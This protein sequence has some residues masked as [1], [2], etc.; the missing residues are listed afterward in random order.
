MKK[1][2]KFLF[3][4]FY[5]LPAVL[6]HGCATTQPQ[7]GVPIFA[8]ARM[9]ANYYETITPFPERMALYIDEDLA[10]YRHERV[11]APTYEVGHSLAPM[12]IEAFQHSFNE[13]VFLEVEPNASIASRYDITYTVWVKLKEFESF[14]RS[15]ETQTCLVL[16]MEVYDADFKKLATFESEGSHSH[17]RG[18]GAKKLGENMGESFENAIT[19]LIESFQKMAKQKQVVL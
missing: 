3:V 7:A 18:I 10:L 13:F 16:T 2:L 19:P 15:K 17:T 14:L 1:N 11:N 6:F 8:P 12:L 4:A 5:F 9:S